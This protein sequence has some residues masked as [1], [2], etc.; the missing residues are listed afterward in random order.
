VLTAFKEELKKLEVV[1]AVIAKTTLEAVTA[2][3]GIGTGKILQAVR[4]SITGAGG[5]PDLMMIMEILGKEEVI[6]RIEFAIS[7][8][9]VAA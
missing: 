7:S 1:D 9:K 3:L 8:L 4:L 5:G 6:R 2:S